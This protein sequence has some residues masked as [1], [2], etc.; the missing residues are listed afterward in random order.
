MLT[1][2]LAYYK[3]PID[4]Q[5][6]LNRENINNQEVINLAQELIDSTNKYRLALNEVEIKSR[7][8]NGIAQVSATNYQ[9][10]ADQDPFLNYQTPS[11]KQAFGSNTLAY[12]STSGIYF[13]PSAEANVNTNN[14]TFDVPYVMAHEMSHQ[15]GFASEDEANYLGYLSCVQSS[16]PYFQYSAY[17]NVGLRTLFKV[18]EI[19]STLFK[20][21]YKNLD[22]LVKLDRQK[23]RENWQKYKNPIQE[24]IIA[25]I[26]DVFLKSNGQ[27]Q[28]SRS[29]DL[30]IDLL[31]AERRK[32]LLVNPNIKTE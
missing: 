29:Y 6:N 3:T 30:V 7:N 24:Y 11:I 19:D 16:N 23:D 17:Y 21:L 10:L 31:V 32:R 9:K 13:F 15:L 8:F 14:L 4:T 12:M 1:W 5:M 20:N 2:G 22:T 25:P 28:G 26:Y 27:K 18:W